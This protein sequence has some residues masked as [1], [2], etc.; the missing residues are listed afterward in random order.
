MA[1]E[2]LDQ[3]ER[4]ICLVRH[5]EAKTKDEDAARP[6][7]DEGRET[8][9]RTAGWAAASGVKVD[10]I[11]HSGKLR[12]QQTAEILAEHIS[13]PDGTIA[14]EGLNPNDDV[15]PVA[16][17]LAQE[18]QT[19]MLVGHLPFLSRLVSHLIT[20]QPDQPVVQFDAAA[21]VI[22]SQQKGQW[23]VLSATQ[24]KLLP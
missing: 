12:A 2:S 21:L 1:A 10:Q 20:G 6:L 18:D 23:S 19:V 5:G 13:P 14:A 7:T 16:D 3:Q 9:H 8:A 24:P 4:I 11:R 22:L 17:S 15:E